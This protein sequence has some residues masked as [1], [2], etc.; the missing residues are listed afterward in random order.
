MNK[1]ISNGYAVM[2]NG[3]KYGLGPMTESQSK[4]L[5]VEINENKGLIELPT[6]IYI[7][8]VYIMELYLGD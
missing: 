8:P 7:N 2:I 5:L 1:I 6:G 4:E 3:S